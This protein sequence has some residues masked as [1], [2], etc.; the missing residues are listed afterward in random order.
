[1]FMKNRM[2]VVRGFFS[3]FI[4]RL[5]MFDHTFAFPRMIW[6]FAL[7]CLGFVNYP[8]SLIIQSVIIM[9]MLYV[10]TTALLYIC[11]SRV[12]YGF[13]NLKSAA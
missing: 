2:N 12:F 9:Y 1:M 13:F 7:I 4:V 10:F 11:I 8:F 3:D 6:Y 5:V